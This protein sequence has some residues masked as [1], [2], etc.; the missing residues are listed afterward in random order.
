MF[1]TSRSWKLLPG[2]VVCAT[3]V[4]IVVTLKPALPVYIGDPIVAVLLGILVG[5]TVGVPSSANQGVLWVSGTGLRLAIVLMGAR[6]TFGAAFHGGGAALVFLLFS[7][8]TASALIVAL[9]RWTRL[10]SKLTTLLA[11]GTAICGNSAIV[12]TAPVIGAEQR[13]V[14]SAVATITLFGT[15]AVFTFP[16]AGVALGLSAPTFG[17][18]AGSAINDTSQVLAAGAAHGAT[19]ASVATIVKLTRNALMAP[20]LVAIGLRT[21][22]IRGSIGWHTALMKS[23]PNFVLAFLV[24]TLANSIGLIPTMGREIMLHVSQLLIVAALVG[25]G[26]HTRLSELQRIGM[27]PF[28]VGLTSALV[29]ALA[30]L[31]AAAL[32]SRIWESV[33]RSL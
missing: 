21:G 33:F 27:R 14:S 7:M 32:T 28:V 12:A 20:V 30:T 11:V 26:L 25:I 2:L 13:E 31:A 23:V 4:A 1:C 29:L 15:L 8:C 9:G 18:W 5:N 3:G 6:V 22:K 24:V 10:P 19:A 17:V 16:L